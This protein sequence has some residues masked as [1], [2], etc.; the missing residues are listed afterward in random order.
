MSSKIVGSVVHYCREKV[1]IS[2]DSAVVKAPQ[3]K[4]PCARSLGICFASIRHGT[5][6]SP[7][8]PDAFEWLW[9]FQRPTKQ[10]KEERAIW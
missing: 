8:P 2:S 7:H 4:S 10:E 3:L 1:V 9:V 6:L 5:G